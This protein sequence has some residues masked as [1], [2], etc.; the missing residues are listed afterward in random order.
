MTSV[1]TEL[2]E[3]WHRV[4]GAVLLASR[5]QEGELPE[6]ELL[7]A[8][9]TAH[10]RESSRLMWVVL[11]WLEEN[12]DRVDSDLLMR[13]T[14]DVGDLSVLGLIADMANERR[15]HPILQR[16]M[17]A[18]KPNPGLEIFFHR[19]ARSATAARLTEA[20]TNDI[21]RRWNYLGWE[22]EHI[23]RPDKAP[24]DTVPA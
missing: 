20:R 21:Y 1:L 23:G 4:G 10:C 18:C 16:I 7:A 14:A 2:F 13:A 9:S 6:A 11:G 22:I 19:V 5:P 15:D 12:V 8:R 3:D 17:A 24:L